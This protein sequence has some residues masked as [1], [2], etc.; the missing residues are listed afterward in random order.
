MSKRKYTS[1]KT[2]PWESG[3]MVDDHM[4]YLAGMVCGVCNV[5]V[6]L[7]HKPSVFSLVKQVVRKPA[8]EPDDRPVFGCVNYH[9]FHRYCVDRCKDAQ[10][11][12][13][14]QIYR[15][16]VGKKCKCPVC[17][18]PLK[19]MDGSVDLR[20]V[21]HTDPL[22]TKTTDLYSR[23]E[24]WKRQS[25]TSWSSRTRRN[26]KS[27]ESK[28]K[29]SREYPDK[30]PFLYDDA[31]YYE[32]LDVD[33]QPEYD[34]TQIKKKYHKL[35]LKYHPDKCGSQFQDINTHQCTAI[36]QKFNKAKDVLMD[37]N[38]SGA[39]FSEM[40]DR[41]TIGRVSAFQGKLAV[42]ER[43]HRIGDK[44]KTATTYMP[45]PPTTAKTVR[46]VRPGRN[47]TVV[48]GGTQRRRSV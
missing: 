21:E 18:E 30:N 41:V 5:D 32:I 20:S 34:V 40:R 39:Y 25:T 19:I 2:N 28:S 14:H 7:P 11:S 12:V 24:K 22:F 31:T 33:P 8:T 47:Y 48:R 42:W 44:P 29:E 37:P 16:L 6:T 9:V 23:H 27:K 26:V 1:R 36:L 10:S 45:L 46:V 17:K 3:F 15:K 43:A 35:A 13:R 4:Y 38:L